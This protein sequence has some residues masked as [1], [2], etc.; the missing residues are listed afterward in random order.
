MAL[1][2]V[3]QRF[4]ALITA[5]EMEL[6]PFLEHLSVLIEDLEDDE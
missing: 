2:E 6:F 5:E 3:Y 4:D 1:F